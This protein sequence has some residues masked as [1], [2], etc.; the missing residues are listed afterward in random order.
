M[1]DFAIVHAVKTRDKR[2]INGVTGKF[3]PCFTSSQET[4]TTQDTD[5]SREAQTT[6][7]QYDKAVSWE[8]GFDDKCLIPFK[9]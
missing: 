8:T 9:L 7:Q 1:Y 6:L 2:Q 4:E 3:N 5:W